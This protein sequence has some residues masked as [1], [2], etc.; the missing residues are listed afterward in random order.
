M[1][2]TPADTAREKGSKGKE[3]A[4]AKLGRSP[5]AATDSLRE[6]GSKGK[7]P[8]P[9]ATR[10]AGKKAVAPKKSGGRGRT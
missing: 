4:P 6:R 8:P 5:A 3:A 7:A 1:P 9:P 10:S 2:V